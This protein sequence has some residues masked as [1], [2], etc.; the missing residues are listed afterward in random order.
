MD[1][2][3]MPLIWV[4]N[5]K[6]SIE[7]RQHITRHLDGLGLDYELIEAVDG[8]ELS[9]EELEQAYCSS[10]AIASIRRE[11]TPGEIGWSL[12]HLRLYQRQVDERLD[13]VVI[14][15]DDVEII[16]AAGRLSQDIVGCLSLEVIQHACCAAK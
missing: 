8:R 10:A 12:S 15:E 3:L 7:R 11:L 14:L 5:L 4:I 6:R 1:H 2:L 9:P 16:T 13:E